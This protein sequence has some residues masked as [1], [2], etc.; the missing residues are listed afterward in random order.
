V[1]HDPDVSRQSLAALVAAVL[2][3]LAI[4]ALGGLATSTSVRTW[5]PTLVRPAFAPPPWIFAPVWTVLYVMMGV[6]SWLVW[7]EGFARPDVRSALAVYGVQ[8]ALNLAWSWLFFGLRQ[9]L[10][11]LIEIVVL[12]ALIAITM[13]RFAP[14]SRTAAGLMLPYLAWVAFATVLNGAFWWLNRHPA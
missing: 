10:V 2:L 4:G 8:L 1:V 5:Y 11:A 6:A 7:R 3:P 14:L 9:P 12:L 13:A